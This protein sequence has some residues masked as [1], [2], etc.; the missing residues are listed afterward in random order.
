MA[1]LKAFKAFGV[2]VAG[3]EH[4]IMG[5]ILRME[6]RRR[7]QL[8]QQSQTEVESRK[9]KSKGGTELKKSE[10]GLHEGSGKKIRGRSKKTH[11][12]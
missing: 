1:M 8:Q 2:N 7:T 5:I 11:S 3:F 10:W 6:E 4:E 9:G 12:R